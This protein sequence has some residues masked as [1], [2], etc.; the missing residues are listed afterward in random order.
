MDLLDRINQT[1]FLGKEFLTGLWYRSDSQ[2]GQFA[3]DPYGLVE[4]W[5]DDKLTLEAAGENVKEVN[6]I[7]CESPTETAEAKAALRMGKKVALAKLRFINGPREWVC[8]CQGDSLDLSGVKVPA[9]LSQ[10]E[11]ERVLE[12]L[13]LIEELDGM[14]DGLYSQFIEL[15]VDDSRWDAEVV[16]MRTWVHG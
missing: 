8:V 10:E 16:K 11:D 15:R 2:D 7:R 5:F 14:L 9:L 4:V 12:R 1:R 13:T 6:S 3:L